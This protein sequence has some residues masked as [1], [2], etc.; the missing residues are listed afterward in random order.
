MKSQIHSQEMSRREF[1]QGAVSMAGTSLVSPL[2]AQSTERTSYGRLNFIFLYTEGQRWDALSLAGKRPG[3]ATG[4]T[5]ITNIRVRKKYARI[6][7]YAPSAS[8]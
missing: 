3:D 6:V 4:F 1:V 5:N 7:D 2:L 8:S